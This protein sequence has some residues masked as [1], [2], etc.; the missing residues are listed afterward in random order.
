MPP[1]T[2]IVKTA[3][4]VPIS[5]Q[6]TA[7]GATPSAAAAATAEVDDDAAEKAGQGGTA[8]L[9][10]LLH[11]KLMAMHAAALRGDVDTVE[12]LYADMADR[13]GSQVFDS[14]KHRV[15]HGFNYL[16]LAHGYAHGYDAA[17]AKLEEARRR[18]AA[19]L[20]IDGRV[21]ADHL[22]R[23]DARSMMSANEV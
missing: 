19:D 12:A 20:L 6:P 7:R 16:I 14:F 23:N 22:E 8:S 10:A 11:A 2:T 18:K 17:R 1:T 13:C 5:H 21:D 4:L 15:S 3:P 9:P